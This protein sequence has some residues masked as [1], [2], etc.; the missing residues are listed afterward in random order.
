LPTLTGW[1]DYDRPSLPALGRGD[2]IDYFERRTRRVALNPLRRILQSE[3]L[4]KDTAGNEIADSSALLIFGVAVCCSI[5]SLGKFANG[6]TGKSHDRFKAFLHKYMSPS[7]Q[8]GRLAGKTYGEILW[9]Y[10]RNGLAH[11]FAVCH[12]GYEGNAG[13]SYFRPRGT[14]LEI[15]PT[16]LLEDL[17]DGFDKYMSDLRCASGTDQIY[18]NF[19]AVFTAVF[20]K[21]K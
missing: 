3:I 11:G 6:G 1:I 19:D 13:E 10:F 14:I 18:K 7:F 5:E 16:S 2:R 15:N 21:G 12:G 9:R 20:I 8:T 17:C 4:P